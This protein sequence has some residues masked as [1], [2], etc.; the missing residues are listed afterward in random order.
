VLRAVLALNRGEAIRAV[1]LLQTAAPYELGT[2]PS[3]AFGF[4]GSLYP[5]YVRGLAYWAE[6][7]G[8]E[9]AAE[10]QKV[11][12]RRNIVVNDPVGALAHL[13]LGRALVISGDIDKA[14]IAYQDFRTLWRYAD[15]DIPILKDANAEYARLLQSTRA[16][17]APLP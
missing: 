15:S 17:V 8:A 16:A 9:A 1:E 10:F 14:M 7:K 5:V 2:P 6:G 4:F 11:I 13:Q 3:S 12:D